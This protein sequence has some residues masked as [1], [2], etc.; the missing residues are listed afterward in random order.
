MARR[1]PRKSARSRPARGPSVACAC[2]QTN[3]ADTWRHTVGTRR[4]VS[5]RRR[6]ACH[7]WHTAPSHDRRSTPPEQ[8]RRPR[9]DR[10][11]ESTNG[12]CLGS[13]N[14]FE[15]VIP[16]QS[17]LLCGRPSW[18]RLFAPGHRFGCDFRLGGFCDLGK[19]ARLGRL[20]ALL[21]VAGRP[22]WRRPRPL[23][24][25]SLRCLSRRRASEYPGRNCL[26]V[27]ETPRRPTAPALLSDSTVAETPPRL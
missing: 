1:P 2:D 23:E 11:F 9:S 6:P 7:R 22:R 18:Q 25:S 19:G 14:K 15:E 17:H 20:A 24:N 5:S 10:R 8:R 27:D 3:R 4:P 12:S 13:R 26:D 21:A 16:L